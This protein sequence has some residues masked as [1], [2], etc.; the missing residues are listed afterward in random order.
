MDKNILFNIILGFMIVS[1]AVI[2]SSLGEVRLDVYISMY[3]LEYFI[4]KA[5]LGPRRRFFDILGLALFLIFSILVCF[6]I[7]EILQA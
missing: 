3:T 4:A 6:R 2:L 5:V 7:W 1:T